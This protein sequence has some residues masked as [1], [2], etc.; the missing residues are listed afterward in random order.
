MRG[1]RLYFW[2]QARGKVAEAVMAHPPP[3]GGEAAHAVHAL[4]QIV[5]TRVANALGLSVGFNALD[6]D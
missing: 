4:T 5:K 6:G 1:Y 3:G 2:P